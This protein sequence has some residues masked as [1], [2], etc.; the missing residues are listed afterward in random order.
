MRT[1]VRS[2]RSW[3]SKARGG[4]KLLLHDPEFAET[5]E[6]HRQVCIR[7]IYKLPDVIARKVLQRHARQPPDGNLEHFYS[8]LVA[9]ASQFRVASCSPNKGGS[10]YPLN[11]EISK[12]SETFYSIMIY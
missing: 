7:A 1:A 8:R 11:I 5:H 9:N 3:L 10:I 4:D 2:Y 12:L 6:G